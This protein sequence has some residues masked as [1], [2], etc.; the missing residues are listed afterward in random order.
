VMDAIILRGQFT[1]RKNITIH[2][3][4]SMKT[5]FVTCFRI[6]RSETFVFV[7][8]D[9]C[10]KFRRIGSKSNMPLQLQE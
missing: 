6:N 5:N 9:L 2:G 3:N 4:D 1:S 10:R 8:I 7:A